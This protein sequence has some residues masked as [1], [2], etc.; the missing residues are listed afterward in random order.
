[1]N[2]KKVTLAG[3]VLLDL[4]GDTALEADVVAGKTFH[5]SNG[6]PAVG[7]YVLPSGELEI[8]ENGVYDVNKKDSVKVNVQPELQSRK[9]TP[10]KSEQKI[11]VTED[12]YYGLSLVTVEKIPDEYLIPNG[13]LHI[14]K[15]T[16]EGESVDVSDKKTVTVAVPI[17]EGYLK[18]AGTKEITENGAAV[19][20]SEYEFAYAN[21]PQ[22]L[23]IEVSTEA[24][25]NNIL[26]TATESELGKV[27]KYTGET[28]DSYENGAIYIIEEAE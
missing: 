17:P 7:E 23:P 3:E 1:M 13:N 25:M 21:V 14:T 4:S 11:S 8:S 19:D 15:N 10:T 22:G 6:E 12:K 18:P 16:G 9:V 27:Y 28:T 5:K 26:S 24:E 20:V 2:L